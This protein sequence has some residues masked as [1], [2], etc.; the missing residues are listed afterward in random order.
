MAYFNGIIGYSYFL[1]LCWSG[2]YFGVKFYLLLQEERARSIKAEAMAQEAQLRMLRYQLNPHFLFNTLNALSTLILERDTDNANQMVQRLSSFLRYSLD[3]DA[4]LKVDLDHEI[5]TMMLYLGIEK[6]RFG[7]R[8]AIEFDIEDAAK[9]ALVP[10]LLLQPLV[11]NSIEYAVANRE[12]GGSIRIRA[13]PF[14]GE[15]I[16]SVCDDG[17]GLPADWDGEDTGVGL[18]N[19][20]DRLRELYGRRHQWHMDNLAPH[21]LCI[22]MRLPLETRHE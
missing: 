5:N 17:P 15:L 9:P 7:E 21:G 1:F 8:L 11:E 6:V 22:E 14:E 18:R 12:D 3:K 2:L 10:S 13:R 16:L 20:Q 4:L 19:T